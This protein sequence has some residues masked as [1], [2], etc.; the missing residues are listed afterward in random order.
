VAVREMATSRTPRDSGF[1]KPGARRRLFSIPRTRNGM[2]WGRCSRFAQQPAPILPKRAVARG[3]IGTALGQ[4]AVGDLL[5]V[6]WPV[7]EHHLAV[8]P[9]RRSHLVGWVQA[10]SGGAGEFPIRARVLGLRGKAARDKRG[11]AGPSGLAETAVV[12][13]RK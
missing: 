3:K 11:Q 7:P 5:K 4:A 12:V 8:G 2:R 6:D 9:F 1:A 13:A 10:R